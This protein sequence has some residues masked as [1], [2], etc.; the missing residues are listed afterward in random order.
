MSSLLSQYSWMTH[1]WWDARTKRGNIVSITK[2]RYNEASLSARISVMFSQCGGSIHNVCICVFADLINGFRVL[3]NKFRWVLKNC[4]L[5]LSI[6]GLNQIKTTLKLSTIFVVYW[7]QRPYVHRVHT[8]VFTAQIDVLY[9]AF[10][11]WTKSIWSSIEF[12]TSPLKCWYLESLISLS[13]KWNASDPCIMWIMWFSVL[14]VIVILYILHLYYNSI[15]ALFLSRK[16]VGPRAFPIIGSALYF[17]NKNSAG[18][19]CN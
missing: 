10:A 1:E 19:L 8:G 2:N 17:L 13:H 3:S 14:F 18:I 5:L 15:R 6:G 11:K 16:T 9:N 7:V 12:N 4:G